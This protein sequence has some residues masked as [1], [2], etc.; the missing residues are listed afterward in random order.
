MET[1]SRTELAV[2]RWMNTWAHDYDHLTQLAEGWEV[3]PNRMGKIPLDSKRG[4]I[5]PFSIWVVS[6]VVFDQ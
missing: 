3:Y 1:G 6:N 4:M 5:N 2:V